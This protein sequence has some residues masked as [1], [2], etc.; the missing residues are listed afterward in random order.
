MEN[1]LYQAITEFRKEMNER[2][3][4]LDQKYAPLSRF[5]LVERIVFGMV[6]LI[7][8]GFMGLLVTNTYAGIRPIGDTKHIATPSATGGNPRPTAIIY[9]NLVGNTL[10]PVR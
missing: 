4:R 9:D 2:F 3:D 10:P 5:E 1:D 8:V 7:V 6:G